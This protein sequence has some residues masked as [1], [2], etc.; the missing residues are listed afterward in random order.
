MFPM[1]KPTGGGV[2]HVQ[3]I[4][5]H[6]KF[7]LFCSGA[8]KLDP[9]CQYLQRKV[10]I[11]EKKGV[12]FGCLESRHM[13]KCVL[14][15]T[16]QFGTSTIKKGPTTSKDEENSVTNGLLDVDKHQWQ[17]LRNRTAFGYHA[18]KCGNQENKTK[19]TYSILALGRTNWSPCQKGKHCHR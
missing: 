18:C 5:D 14:S 13:S 7:C 3:L 9:C 17:H 12:C 16:L 15:S 6:G 8:Q 10:E 11:F 19:R 1:T 2:N 4:K